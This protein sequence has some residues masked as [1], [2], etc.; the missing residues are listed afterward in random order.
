MTPVGHVTP[1]ARTAPFDRYVLVIIIVAGVVLLAVVTVVVPVGVRYICHRRKYVCQMLHGSRSVRLPERHSGLC[2]DCAL[3]VSQT[4][5]LLYTHTTTPPFR[6]HFS[7]TLAGGC[8]MFATC[9]FVRP[10]VRPSVRY[11]TRELISQP[12]H[13][14][15]D[16]P[17]DSLVNPSVSSS[18]LSSSITPSLFHL[19]GL[20]PT[21]LTNLSH[22]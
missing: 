2:R 16:S 5:L 13:S 8:I 12:H 10:S 4:D 14:C 21:F 15:L 19:A 20:K 17:L 7:F 9:P 6:R 18:P 22:L 3:T 1:A 11:Q